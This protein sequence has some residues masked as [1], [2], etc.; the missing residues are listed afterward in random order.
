MAI[1]IYL[2]PRQMGKTKAKDAS[3]A[4]LQA[5]LKRFEAQLKEAQSS[6][7]SMAPRL[8]QNLKNEIEETKQLIK[9]ATDAKDA[10]GRPW[11]RV[12]GVGFLGDYEAWG[13]A[14]KEHG[15]TENEFKQML[16]KAKVLGS[17]QGNAALAGF[18]NAK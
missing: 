1:H 14:A 3:K 2:P 12:G 13:Q 10:G 5:R 15:L 18:N 7:S 9:R 8:V 11:D 4:D 17:R 16:A 6:N